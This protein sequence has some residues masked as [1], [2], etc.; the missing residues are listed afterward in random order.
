M[1][2]KYW[3]FNF[4]ARQRKFICKHLFEMNDWILDKGS[5]K[6]LFKSN[7]KSILSGTSP[8]FV[9]WISNICI[10]NYYLHP[11]GN[12][13]LTTIFTGTCL[14]KLVIAVDSTAEVNFISIGACW[15]WRILHW[16][17]LH[18]ALTPYTLDE[19]KSFQRARR[20]EPSW[21]FFDSNHSTH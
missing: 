20:K 4:F 14:V 16:H 12:S 19:T 21:T 6:S 5:F 8:F 10:F 15:I 9:P 11:S 7:K 17:L 18:F 13:M 1:D 2:Q 3:Q